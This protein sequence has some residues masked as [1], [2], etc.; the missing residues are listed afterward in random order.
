MA[1]LEFLTQRFKGNI[2]IF[3]T[4]VPETFHFQLNSELQLQIFKLF[5][6]RLQVFILPYVTISIKISSKFRK[7]FGVDFALRI[8]RCNQFFQ[9]IN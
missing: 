1:L 4:I 2:E 3:Q 9:S 7:L 5:V 8:F 6:S